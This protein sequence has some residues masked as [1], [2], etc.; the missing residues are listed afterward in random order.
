[1]SKIRPGSPFFLERSINAVLIVI[2]FIRGYL[3][4]GRKR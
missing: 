4:T 1:M 3:A 2:L